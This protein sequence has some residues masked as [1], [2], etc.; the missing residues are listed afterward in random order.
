MKSILWL[1]M[2]L[3]STG[4]AWAEAPVSH[5]MPEQ[6]QAI[7]TVSQAV[8]AAKKVKVTDPALAGLR[9]GIE[10]A[11]AMVNT[12]LALPPTV[13]GNAELKPMTPP[14]S[15]AA[16]VTA[17]GFADITMNRLET[18]HTKVARITARRE[19]SLA[20]AHGQPAPAR[21]QMVAEAAEHLQALE[22]ELDTTL[23]EPDET[24]IAHLAQI[25]QRLTPKRMREI[26]VEN[27][28]PGLQP[29]IIT[30]AEHVVPIDTPSVTKPG[31]AP[32][33]PHRLK[34]VK[35]KA[36]NQGQ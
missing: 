31:Q 4:T 5:L 11:R 17:Q 8:L 9:Q 19:Q 2:A 7:R 15:P 10:D 29:T 32:A 23:T 3:G 27:A 30:L 24:R 14:S 28:A 20:A 16:E 6:I 21:A 34:V 26:Q 22:Q 35:P 36:R 13:Q 25:R 1:L 12:E 18:A 33:T